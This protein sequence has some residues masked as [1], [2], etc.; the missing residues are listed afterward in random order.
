MKKSWFQIFTRTYKQAANCPCLRGSSYESFIQSTSYEKIKRFC[1][2]L[3]NTWVEKC[4]ESVRN[5]RH[6]EFKEN[7]Y[8]IVRDFDNFKITDEKAKVGLVGEILVKYHPTANNDIVDIVER[9]GAEAVMPDLIGFS[10]T[11][12]TAL[13]SGTPI[14]QGKRLMQ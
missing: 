2:P 9:E 13:I 6:K 12:L 4:K 1:Q 3:Y 11:W 5:G 7:I 8:N 10:Y 14:F